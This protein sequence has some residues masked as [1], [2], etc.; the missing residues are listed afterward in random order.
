MRA[1]NNIFLVRVPI[2]EAVD[3][4]ELRD[5]ILESL[6]RGVLVLTEDASCEVLELPP[7]GGVE[8]TITETPNLTEEAERQIT[9]PELPAT[10]PSEGD[11]K[12]AILQRL[13][14]YRADHGPGCLAVVSARTAR[15]KDRRISDDVLRHICADG[16]P[17]LPMEDWRSIGRALDLLEQAEA[18]DASV[19][20]GAADG[21]SN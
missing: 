15:R 7:L 9:N 18:R 13:K 17:K 14:N 3:G 19:A 2:Q 11:E 21:N 10:G 12:R 5:Y 8:I 4:R 6:A 16:A 1:A 20:K